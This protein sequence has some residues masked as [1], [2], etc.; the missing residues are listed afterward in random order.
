MRKCETCLHNG[1]CIN[2]DCMEAQGKQMEECRDWRD[3]AE[4]IRV[5]RCRDC[6]YAREMSAAEAE[7]YP[8]NTLICGDNDV[9]DNGYMPVRADHYCA[10]GRRKN[11][12]VT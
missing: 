12:P 11:A 4:Y 7:E 3:K 9:S 1:F 8:E 5:V 6:R 10:C 2:Q